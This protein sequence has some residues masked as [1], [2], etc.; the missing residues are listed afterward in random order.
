MKLPLFFCQN[1]KLFCIF[2]STVNFFF[3][4]LNGSLQQKVEKCLEDGIRLPMLD[5]KQ[6][7]NENECLKEKNEKA[8]KVSL[9]TICGIFDLES[10]ICFLF[11][12][13]FFTLG[14]IISVTNYTFIA[15]SV[16]SSISASL[17][18]NYYAFIS[19]CMRV[20][21]CLCNLVFQRYH[22]KSVAIHL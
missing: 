6:L 11:V 20:K 10:C 3:F 19:S 18:W 21:L 14:T 9:Q 15:K 7:Q 22:V 16:F 1:I 12:I 5:T 13:L 4:I 8:S 2:L 17:Q